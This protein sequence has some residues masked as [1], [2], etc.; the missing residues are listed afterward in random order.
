MCVWSSLSADWASTGYGCQS[1]L[2]SAEQGKRNFLCPRSR[3]RIW[4][5]ELD[6]AVSSRVSPL[7]LH[8][9]AESGA[10]LRDSTSPSRFPLRFPLEQPCAIGLG[11]S[12][13]YRLTQLRYRWRSLPRTD[14]GPVVLKVALYTGAS[15]SG[16]PM[17]QSKYAPL[18]PY[19]LLVQWACASKKEAFRI[20]QEPTPEPVITTSVGFG[21]RKSKSPL[22]L[23]SRSETPG[24]LI[25]QDYLITIIAMGILR[26]KCC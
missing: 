5:L 14:T 7:V 12:R 9:Q 22:F 8:T 2:W 3:L 17:D 18:F 1:C 15:S 23:Q 21:Q 11:W 19:P 25:Y 16:K 4:S 20:G 13:V 26:A 24:K 10:Y 6:S